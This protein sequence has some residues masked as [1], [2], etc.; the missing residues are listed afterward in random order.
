MHFMLENMMRKS[1]GEPLTM[2]IDFGYGTHQAARDNADRVSKILGRR[3]FQVV[4][5]SRLVANVPERKANAIKAAFPE[6]V[7]GGRYAGTTHSFG[8]GPQF[9][10]EKC[11]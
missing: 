6:I 8:D 5:F 10:L 7:D 4:G 2:L 1:A 9:D 11:R 3:N